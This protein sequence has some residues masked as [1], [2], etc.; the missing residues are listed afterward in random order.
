MH[1]EIEELVSYHLKTVFYLKGC[2]EETLLSEPKELFIRTLSLKAFELEND[3]VS[4]LATSSGGETPEI[5]ICEQVML[6]LIKRVHPKAY[7]KV[8]R[9]LFALESSCRADYDASHLT[10]LRN[11]FKALEKELT[12]I[13]SNALKNGEDPFKANGDEVELH[14]YYTV[15]IKYH[16]LKYFYT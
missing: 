5:Y 12:E 8:H 11:E 10:G 2:G 9:Y 16:V 3:K 13:V 4:M 7:G 15:S 14:N 1:T 6:E